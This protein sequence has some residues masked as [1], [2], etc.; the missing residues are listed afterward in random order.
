MKLNDEQIVSDANELAREFYLAHGYQVPSSF[1]FYMSKHPQ[2]Q[3]MWRL[4]CLAY[5]RLR[6][7]PVDDALAN[8]SE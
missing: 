4:A 5:E 6:D 3:L 2:E 1:C 7:T 8:I